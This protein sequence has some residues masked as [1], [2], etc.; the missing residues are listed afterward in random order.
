[1]FEV[2]PVRSRELQEELAK[3]FG[4]PM[5]ENTY[6]FFAADMTSDAAQITGILG[7][8]QF[9]YHPD[10]A[11]IK[12]IAAAPGKKDDEAI[13]VMVRTVMS[14]CSRAGIPDISAIPETEVSGETV[15]SCEL[16]NDIKF[17]NSLGFREKSDYTIDLN[18]FYRS[19]CHYKDE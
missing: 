1:M 6:A 8:C 7:L 19:P 13:F 11:A 14:F 18:K 3:L 16:I 17:I 5:F 9:E 12:S 10:H 15:D 4:V 2:Q